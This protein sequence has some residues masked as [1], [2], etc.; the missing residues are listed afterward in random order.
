MMIS[1]LPAC[2]WSAVEACLLS[3]ASACVQPAG[4]HQGGCMLS[5]ASGIATWDKPQP[6]VSRLHAARKL[7]VRCEGLRL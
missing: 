2:T 3:R 7:L 4:Q 5:A 1:W 6:L